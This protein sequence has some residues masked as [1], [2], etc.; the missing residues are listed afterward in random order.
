MVKLANPFCGGCG[1]SLDE[2]RAQAELAK[3]GGVWMTPGPGEA[4]PYRPIERSSAVIRLLCGA[5]AVS[6]LAVAIAS[7]VAMGQSR[8]MFNSLRIDESELATLSGRLQLLM[9]GLM[10]ALAIVFIR[11]TTVAYRNLVP[12]GVR[13]MRINPRLSTLVWFVPFGNFV[14]PKEMID[15]LYRGSDPTAPVL[16]GAW[17][18]RTVPARFHLWWMAVIGGGVL[19]MGAQWVLPA[20]PAG[21]EIDVVGLTLAI[22]AHTLIAAAALLTALLV[23]DVTDRQLARI[24]RLGRAG[25]RARAAVPVDEPVGNDGVPALVHVDSASVWGRY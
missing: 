8:T 13:G 1:M 18:L 24:E 9:L 20:P 4:R 16:S 7:G 3:F 25:R 21:D 17:R 19:L 11:W 14:W 23:S 2:A 22:A 5:V 6:A 15:D 12:L 10:A